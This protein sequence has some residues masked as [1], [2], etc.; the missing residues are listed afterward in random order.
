MATTL[1]SP[2]RS[3]A[4][5]NRVLILGVGWSGYQTLLDMVREQPTRITYDRG[6]VELMSPLVQHELYSGRFTLLVIALTEA[7]SVPR[8]AAG[9]TTFKSKLHDRG[10][11]PDECFYLKSAH[12]LPRIGPK[13]KTQPPPPDLAIEIELT[14]SAL[15]RMGIHAALGVPEVW[16]FDGEQL[17][18]HVLDPNRQYEIHEASVAFPCL[19]I[20]EVPRWITESDATNDTLW[21]LALRDWIRDEVVPRTQT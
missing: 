16:R 14:T 20:S 11:E 18:V 21:G 9:S 17:T 12:L 4:G 2:A 1:E 15:D 8:T 10:L 13:S 7:L 5:E 19:P 3:A 6:D